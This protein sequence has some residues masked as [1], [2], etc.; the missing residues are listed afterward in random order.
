MTVW[1]TNQILRVTMKWGNTYVGYFAED[2][3]VEIVLEMTPSS[4]EGLRM[5]LAKEDIEKVENLYSY[6]DI[7]EGQDQ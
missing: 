2:T 1:N 4:G 5:Y 6:R 3:G 7:Q